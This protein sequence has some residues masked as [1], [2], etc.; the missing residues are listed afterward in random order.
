M[1][2]RLLIL[3]FFVSVGLAAQQRPYYTQYIMNNY[4]INPAVAGIENY[5]DIKASHRMQWVGIQDAPVTTYLTIHGPLKKSAY[6]R[7]SATS[8]RARGENPRGT[9]YWRDYQSVEPHGGVGFTMIND[10]TGPLNRFAAYGTYAY[11]L[12]ISPHTNLS[13]GISAGFTNMSLDASKLNFGTV[14]V[15]PAV[16]G[17]GTLNRI[18]PDISAGLWLYSNNYFV[19]LSAQQIVPQNISSSDNSVSLTQGKLIP[20]LFL[21]AGYRMQ[22]SDDVSFLPSALIRY[23]SPLPLGIDLNAK[24]QY[25][26]ILWLGASYRYNDGF[27]AMM[28]FNL[29]NTINIGYSYDLQTSKINTVSK[30]TH[31]LLIGFMLGNKWGDWCPRNLW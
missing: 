26:D 24:F 8:F 21:S 6:E 17:S 16:A 19:G 4:I 1:R 9:A 22:V 27:A 18:K 2:G 3:C 5:T 10:R 12:G 20:H 15:D 14:N 23:V 28:G 25:Q 29:N 7:E 13:A 30:G 31:E 11:H